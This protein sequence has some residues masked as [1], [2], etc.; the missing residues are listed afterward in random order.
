MSRPPLLLLRGTRSPRRPHIYR[1]CTRPSGQHVTT[2]TRSLFDS[3]VQRKEKEQEEWRQKAQMIRS[4]EQK[5][6]LSILEE[7]GFIKDIAGSRTGLDHLL[8]NKRTAAYAGID[9]TAASLHLGHLLPLMILFWLHIHGYHTIS[10]LGG[11]TA[12]VGDPTGRLS[13]RSDM[14]HSTCLSNLTA[15]NIQVRGLWTNLA[16]L[17]SRHG[18]KKDLSWKR[19]VW[20]NSTWL[21]KLTMVDFLA[22]LGRGARMGTMLGRDT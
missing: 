1:S 17:A 7:R 2:T 11:A 15:M 13:S 6:M 4:G 22:V 21:S 12:K 9:P 18:Y 8:T 19:D 10:L 14:D 5:S 20:N 3:T 16:G